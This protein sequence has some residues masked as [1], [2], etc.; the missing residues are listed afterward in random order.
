MSRG[1][2]A[3]INLSALQHNFSVVR[4]LAP[5]SRILSVVKA[6]AYGHGLVPVAKALRDS[7]GFGVA[8][9]LEGLALREA[10]ISQPI[11]LME[12]V[13]N[14]ADLRLAEEKRFHIVIHQQWQLDML[15]A[16]TLSCP[17][18]VWLKV[19]TGMHRLGVPADQFSQSW[20]ALL[21]S[22]N[23]D[24][25][26]IMSHLA[27]ADEQDNPMNGA[28]SRA[29]ALLKQGNQCPQASLA[30]SAGILRGEDYH[31]Q[32]LRPGLML[33]GAS[34]L[35]EA[36]AESLQ[37]KPAM[38]LVSRIIART[39]VK[40]G[41]TV[42]YG[43]TWRA[44]KDSEIAVV[45]IG[46]GDGYPR[47]ISADAHVLIEGVMCPIVGRVSM[48]MITV[49]VTHLP[50]AQPDTEVI[51]WGEGLPV[52]TVAQWAGTVNYELLCQITGRVE[53][54]YVQLPVSEHST[55][56]STRSA[57]AVSAD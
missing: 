52:E 23:V 54:E 17:L 31:Y 26:V 34:P 41:D 50:Q 56:P 25:V 5:N 44:P 7:D 39:Q 1:T 15:L 49:D 36:S 18:N 33:Y 16:A 9:L 40:A 11:L 19:D 13:M 37:L 24:Q 22:A 6:D 14:A 12:G 8:T 45:A 30:N 46:Y 35:Q 57:A 48:D 29:F 28:Q 38:Q 51:L 32:W 10:G 42:G 20:Q 27:C 47:H 43:G 53:R 55:H 21:S 3:V 4:K 2:Q